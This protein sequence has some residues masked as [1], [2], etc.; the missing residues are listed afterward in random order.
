MTSSPESAAVAI[1]T[2]ATLSP[3]PAR[4]TVKVTL[5]PSVASA[6][7][8]EKLTGS[9]VSVSVTVAPVIVMS[10]RV[11]VTSMVSLASS[12]SSSTG[13]TVKLPVWLAAPAAMVMLK[14][15]TAA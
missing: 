3:A 15:L 4:L 1:F 13:V 12:R 7:A 9:S 2:D 14:P 8:I 5:P 6:S 10:V 11:P